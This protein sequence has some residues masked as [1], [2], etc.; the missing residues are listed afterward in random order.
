LEGLGMEISGVLRGRLVFLQP[1]WYLFPIL[2][3]FTKDNL[4]TLKVMVMTD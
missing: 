2:V 4:S 3:Y 1:F